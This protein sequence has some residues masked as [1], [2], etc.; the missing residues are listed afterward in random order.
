MKYRIEYRQNVRYHTE[1]SE[2]L[3]G[4]LTPYAKAL[5]HAQA[6][7]EAKAQD[8]IPCAAGFRAECRRGSVRTGNSGQMGRSGRYSAW[9]CLAQA[10]SSVIPLSFKH[11]SPVSSREP[12]L[13]YRRLSRVIPLLVVENEAE[14]IGFTI[15]V[16]A[17]A[18][19]PVFLLRAVSHSRASPIRR[20]FVCAV[21]SIPSL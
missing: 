8:A 16:S 7:Q 21:A 6:R 5:A 10:Q 17:Q 11:R 4:S 19:A 1:H 13:T 20:G 15:W 9:H 14:N 18:R 3:P 12:F 2:W